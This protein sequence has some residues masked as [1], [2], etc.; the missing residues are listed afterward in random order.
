MGKVKKNIVKKKEKFKLKCNVIIKR[1]IY[2]NTYTPVFN[3]LKKISK[4]SIEALV[5]LKNN[6]FD[7]IADKGLEIL[8]KSK[9]SETSFVYYYDPKNEEVS[10]KK[11]KSEIKESEIKSKIILNISKK[12]KNVEIKNIKEIEILKDRYGDDVDFIVKVEKE[13]VYEKLV[14]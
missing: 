13:Y 12:E 7:C 8:E 2:K 6:N 5:T 9:V 4:E 14:V 11:I 3:S 10:Y 1:E